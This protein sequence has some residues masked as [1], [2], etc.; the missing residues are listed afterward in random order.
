MTIYLFCCYARAID[1]DLGCT[2]A[3]LEEMVYQTVDANAM[4][5]HVHI[6]LMVT[7]G[8]KPTPY[9]NPATTIG[10]PTI[11]I[12]AE[13]KAASEGPK[14]EGIRLMTSHVRR[15]A[16]DVQD[17]AWNSHSKLNC[18]AACIQANK[19]GVDESLMLDP[20]GFVATCNSV[21]FF[22]VVDGAV[23]TSKP[24]YILHGITRA[25]II[26]VARRAGVEVREDDFSL[27]TVYSAEEAFV[28]GTFAGLIPVTEVDGRV[29]GSGRRGAVVEKL[30][31][32]YAE[33]VRE[34]AGRGRGA[35]T[36]PR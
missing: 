21:H 34:E 6:R 7:R 9:Q 19:C 26:K 13:F 22:V 23:L 4:R 8:L 12:A 27:T 32:L 18:I 20:N 16:P 15:G 31:G 35:V 1:M 28:T 5:D 24:K 36:A 33:L 14:R 30:Q 10:K 17:P 11:V 25:N 3:E 2:P 29:I